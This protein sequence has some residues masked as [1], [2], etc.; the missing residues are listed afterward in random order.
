MARKTKYFFNPKSLSFERVRDNRSYVYWRAV[1]FT[2]VVLLLGVAFAFVFS[3]FFASPRERG[4][5]DENR[6]LRSEI[7]SINRNIEEIEAQMAD[8]KERDLKIYRA[9]YEADPPKPVDY[10]GAD[11]AELLKLPEGELIQRIHQKLDRLEAESKA[12]VKSY[13]L[14]KSLVRTREQ[15]IN[16]I[17]AIQP[18]ANRDLTRLA[19]GFGYRLD[20]FYHTATFHAGMDFTADIGTEVYSTGDGVVQKSMNDGWGY[21]NHVIVDHGF[22]YTTLYGHLSRIAVMPGTRVK[23]GQVIGYVGSTG[24]STGPHLHYEVRK[25]GNPLNPAFFYHS[26]LTDEQYRRMIEMSK[27][28][29]KR[30][31]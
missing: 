20:P 14:L 28:E 7:R 29:T 11:Y 30:F 21:G 5:M 12:Q 10:R 13:D 31:D 1:G 4:I 18:V 22:G 9:M 16:S 6:A 3:R 8:L 26:D 2:S 17:P 23:R 15:V 19:S 24:R 25:N 27:R